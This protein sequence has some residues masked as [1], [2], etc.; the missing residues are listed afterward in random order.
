MGE[1]EEEEAEEAEQ[2]GAAPL[3]GAAGAGAERSTSAA[4]RPACLKLGKKARS[5]L[6]R[7]T[8]TVSEQQVLLNH[9]RL[10]AE[11]AAAVSVGSERGAP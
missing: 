6:R 7:R 8:Q 3:P 9:E 1:E 10:P 2:N 11:R 4:A 5:S